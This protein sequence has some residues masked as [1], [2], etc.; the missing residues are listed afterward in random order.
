MNSSCINST[1][2]HPKISGNIYV[3]RFL[4][5]PSCSD[6][7]PFEGVCTVDTTGKVA[8]VYGMCGRVRLKHLR[9]LMKWFLDMG[10]TEVRAH[11][12]PLH[13]LP[14]AKRVGDWMVVDLIA[15]KKRI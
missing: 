13:V 3:V 15:L 5:S 9:E 11:R 4:T 14:G 2:I 1:V 8:R 6:T 7:A 10:V 12:A